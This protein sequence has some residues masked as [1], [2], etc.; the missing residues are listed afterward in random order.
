MSGNDTMYL[1]KATDLGNRLL[2]IF[3]TVSRVLFFV[4]L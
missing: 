1:E 3:D 4:V 2:P